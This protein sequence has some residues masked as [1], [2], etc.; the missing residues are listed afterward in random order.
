MKN[1]KIMFYLKSV[2]ATLVMTIL[3]L[4]V[5]AFGMIILC[6]LA[7]AAVIVFVA[8]VAVYVKRYKRFPR[9][10]KRNKSRIYNGT[11]YEH[12]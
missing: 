2:L 4:S 9:L 8:G 11:Y 6:I 7:V 12:K 5:L 3:V 1:Q 10:F